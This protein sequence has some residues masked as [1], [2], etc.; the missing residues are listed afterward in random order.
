MSALSNKETN[1]KRGVESDFAFFFVYRKG[2][3][4]MDFHKVGNGYIVLERDGDIA[5]AY[6]NSGVI[7]E[8]RS[9]T[10]RNVYKLAKHDILYDMRKASRNKQ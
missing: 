4:Y 3:S 5:R 6:T 9:N 1:I 8:Q 10:F 2:V 7:V